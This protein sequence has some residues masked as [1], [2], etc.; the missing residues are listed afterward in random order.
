MGLYFFDASESDEELLELLDDELDDEE[1]FL[2]LLFLLFM[3]GSGGRYNPGNYS[4]T[5]I[6]TSF[7]LVEPKQTSQD[8]CRALKARFLCCSYSTSE[9]STLFYYYVIEKF[10]FLEV[11]YFQHRCFLVLGLIFA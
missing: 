10:N 2:F 3:G 5:K 7:F 4:R 8:G 1:A 11:S 9:N 6:P